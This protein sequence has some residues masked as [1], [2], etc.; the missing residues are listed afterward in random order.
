[1]SER[2][3]RMGLGLVLFAIVL[4]AYIETMAGSS[5]F[6]DCGEFIA[7]AYSLGIPHPPATPLYVVLGRVFAL[8]PLPLSIA[9]KVN[10]MSAL[11]GALGV[12]V[13]FLIVAHV[14]RERRGEPRSWLDH[15]VIYGSAL[16]GALFTAW[17]N[18]YWINAV[19]AEV[20]SI[21]SFV[22]G[23][24]T[25]LA[26]RWSRDPENPAS[27]RSI[28]LIIYLLSL[29][30]GFHLGTVLT[31]PAI[32]LYMLMFRK[33]S[34]RDADLVI[35]SCGFFLFL[36]HV[37]LKFGGWP[38]A[39][40]LVVFLILFIIRA[41]GGHRFVPV[42]TFLF[43]LGITIHFFLMIRSGQNPA[44]DEADPENF[45]NLM[46]VLR[47]EQ[48]PP[49]NPFERK[50]TW[51]FRIVD[52][53]WR[54]FTEQYQLVRATSGHFTGTRLA[55]VPI[56]VGLAG[57]VSVARSSLRNFVLLF[58]TLLITSLGM[59]FFLNFSDHEVRER[60]YFY[61]PAFY[62]FGMFIG[63][64]AAAVLDWFFGPRKGERSSGIDRIGYV[65]G[66]VIFLM[67]TGMLYTRYHFEHDRTRER[68]PWGYG[69]NML[70]G[71]EP[72]ALIFTNGDNDTFPLWYQQEVEQFRRDVR[73]I[74]LSLLNTPWYPKQLRD[75][76][77]KVHLSWSDHD[78]H[79][80]GR[81]AWDVSIKQK[82]QY[83]PRDLAV[84]QILQDNYGK[85]EIYF[86]VTIPREALQEF[87]DHL[88]LEGLVY[89]FQGQRGSL[90]MRDHEKIVH[91]VD[92]VY[93]FDGILTADG[94][95]DDGIYRDR[96]QVTLV[97]NY[98]SAFI[99]LGQHHMDQ[100]E[101]ATDPAVREVEYVEAVRRYRQALEISPDFQELQVLLGNLYQRMGRL[102]D[103]LE[104][105]E[106][107]QE[108]D[109]GN[110]RVRFELARVNLMLERYDEALRGFRSMARRNPADEF[111][112]QALI[113]VLWQLGR[114]QEAEQVVAEWEARWPGD[115][116]MREFY[117]DVLEGLTPPDWY[118]P[119]GG[120]GTR[121]PVPTGGDSVGP[122]TPEDAGTR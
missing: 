13:L 81:M 66:I 22:M 43:V 11:F 102:E 2:R 92:N 121:T 55:Y 21:S 8:L 100:A 48:Y 90:G 29:G 88:V 42:S 72:N 82:K 95:H 120:G 32:A 19:E 84:F 47:R 20:Y 35:F 28:Y 69:Y 9:Q 114:T 1:M 83:Q 6:W 34:F 26:L 3:L 86:A 36:F 49:S 56:L 71:L 65:G 24:T 111:P 16:V 30:V 18:T 44:I 79:N 54:Y 70:A 45:T 40:A 117:R 119:G 63:L 7:A 12:V 46:A 41:A 101:R 115:T 110:E 27:T 97:Q 64:G 108:R 118:I 106:Q 10:F 17:S 15:V 51:Y 50:A 60:D 53:F 122:G 58:G 74:N 25:L 73:V 5:S 68:I 57:I 112:H 104:L 14:L 33:R 113:Q 4:V 91:N 116:R 87:R 105:Y 37:N 98:A 109:P 80:L 75:N 67:L 39:V 103:S 31:Y 89:R 78:I 62:F 85:K 59:I 99:R 77:P 93:R 107:L 23:L 61:S 96:N 38:A 52:H 94:K 76:E